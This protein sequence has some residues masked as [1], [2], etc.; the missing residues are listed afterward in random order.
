[1]GEITCRNSDKKETWNTKK[2]WHLLKTNL[3]NMVVG[4]QI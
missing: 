2:T 1:M 3:A 4:R